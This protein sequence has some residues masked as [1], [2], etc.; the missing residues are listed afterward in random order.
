MNLQTLNGK[1]WAICFSKDI[2]IIFREPEE[3]SKQGCLITIYNTNDNNILINDCTKVSKIALDFNKAKDT[4]YSDTKSGI[5][6]FSLYTRVNI[7]R[8]ITDLSVAAENDVGGT[9]VAIKAAIIHDESK[10][11][12]LTI[13]GDIC[14]IVKGE[15][16]YDICSLWL[17]NY[18]SDR[19]LKITE[20]TK[21]EE[22]DD[23]DIIVEGREIDP[24]II[25]NGKTVLVNLKSFNV[26]YKRPECKNEILREK[27]FATCSNCDIF[28]VKSFCINDKVRC[29]FQSYVKKRFTLMIPLFLLQEITKQSIDKK[30]LFLQS[31]MTQHVTVQYNPNDKVVKL[32]TNIE[33]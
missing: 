13:F 24:K 6:E 28:T 14:D 9:M 4:V 8:K 23:L 7:K 25:K 15:K 21:L 30:S 3:S 22:I 29:V 2:Y 32:L 20:I 12:P 26:K 19:M 16:C 1:R 11:A 5:N 33:E 17:S 27:D 10:F 31:L 18:K